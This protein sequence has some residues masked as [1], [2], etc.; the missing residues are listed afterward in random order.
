MLVRTIY[1]IG[2]SYSQDGGKTWSFGEPSG[3]PSP[4]SR[5]GAYAPANPGN[6]LLVNHYHFTPKTHQYDGRDHLW[7]LLSLD[8]CKTF[9]PGLEL[10]ERANVSYPDAVQLENGLILTAYDR[11][12]SGAGEI[13]LARYT[14]EDLRLG[15]NA[16][17][18]VM[19]KKVVSSL[20]FERT[21]P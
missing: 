11:D 19:L 16:S 14:E 15:K 3:I 7:A 1:G 8:D 21:T 2:K 12:R 13:L 20:S 9:C 17:G 18:Q 10:D 6:A 4:S 5:G